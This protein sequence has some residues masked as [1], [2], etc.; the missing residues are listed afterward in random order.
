MRKAWGEYH[1]SIHNILL[2]ENPRLLAD[3]KVAVEKAKIVN[4]RLSKLNKVLS[5]LEALCKIKKIKLIEGDSFFEPINFYNKTIL[6][7]QGDIQGGKHQTQYF[8]D[9][10]FTD[11]WIKK[12]QSMIDVSSNKLEKLLQIHS[13]LFEN[14]PKELR[15]IESRYK[16]IKCSTGRIKK[17]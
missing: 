16:K 7:M 15:L 1:R 12:I 5:L 17:N 11:D 6:K 4:I 2:P 3:M 13:E 9:E 14:L 8:I 10:Y